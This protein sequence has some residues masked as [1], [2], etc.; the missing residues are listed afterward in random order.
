MYFGVRARSTPKTLEKLEFVPPPGVK[1]EGPHVKNIFLVHEDMP[2]GGRTSEIIRLNNGME[3]SVY[4]RVL[5]KEVRRKFKLPLTSV[6]P[7]VRH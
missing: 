6:E 7:S 5:P 2:E 1:I 3:Y 4:G